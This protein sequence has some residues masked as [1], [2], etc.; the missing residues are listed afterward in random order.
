MLPLPAAAR[1]FGLVESLIALT[2]AAVL[3]A[4]ALP[5]FRAQ[6]LKS[7]RADAT[8]SLHQLQLQQEQY[9]E[10]HGRYAQSLQQLTGQPGALSAR[11]HYRIDLQAAGPDAYALVASAQGTQTRDTDCRLL[12]LRIEGALSFHEPRSGC[13]PT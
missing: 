6:Q 11:G 9:R 7:H 5:S 8:G 13:W 12:S 1:G 2:V 10:R 3:A 4:V